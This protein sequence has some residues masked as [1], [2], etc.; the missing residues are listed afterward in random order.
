MTPALLLRAGWRQWRQQP[1]QPVLAIAGIALGVAVVLAVAIATDSARLSLHEALERLGGRATHTITAG[2]AGVAQDVYRRLRVDAGL[3]E[4]APVVEGWLQPVATP[5]RW[6]R[7]LGFDPFAE[8]GFGRLPGVDA[9]VDTGALLTRPR[10]ILLPAGLAAQLGLRAGDTVEVRIGEHAT[11]LDVAGT[12]AADGGSGDWVIADIATAQVLLGL[13]DRITRID[14]RLDAAAATALAA[15][16]PPGVTLEAAGARARTG[17]RLTA[18]FELNLTAMSLLALLVGTFLIYETM[19]FSVLRR[20]ALFGSLR[21]LGVTRRE[22]LAQVLLEAAALGVLGTA[23][24]LLLGSVLGARL[25]PLVGRTVNDLYYPLVDTRLHLPPGVFAGCAALGL[26]ATVLAALAPAWEAA[27]SAPGRASNRAQYENRWRR[28]SRQLLLGAAALGAAAV[29]VLA[30]SDGLPGGFGAL[31]LLVLAAT[32]AT[33]R[34]LLAFTAVLAPS[35]ERRTG[36]LARLAVRDL[37]RN[38]SRTAVAAA[39][40]AVAFGAALGVTLMV[41]SFRAGVTL[42]LEDL[43]RADVYAAPLAGT[44]GHG[45]VPLAPAVI[46]AWRTVPGVVAIATYRRFD[47]R[48]DEQPV[49]LIA[50]TLPPAARAGYRLSDGPP[51]RAWAA[52]DAGAVLVSEPLAYR[53]KLAPGA[54]LRLPTDAGTRDFTVAGVFHDYGSE[55]GRILLDH[56]Q[57]GHFWA[58]TRIGSVG[59]FVAAGADPTAVRARLETAAAPLQAVK[60]QG[61]R[62]ILALSLAVFERTFTITALLRALAVGVAFCGVLSSLLAL[63]LERARDFA[64]LRAL[65]LTPAELGRLVSLECGVLGL[66]SGLLALPLGLG[67]GVLLIEVINRR[68]F[69]W[70]MPWAFDPAALLQTVLLALVAALLAGVYPSWRLAHSRP[71]A[72]LR[73]E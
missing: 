49:Q 48:I 4:A 62:D 7:L 40:L 29:A 2:P 25:V 30:G 22:L 51:E 28:L 32:L 12:F 39:A 34:L 8:T 27:G 18:A 58:D 19:T 56:A 9:D 1:W 52:F 66:A 59:V 46:A 43:L 3:H 36:P 31:L 53:L 63:Q 68:A 45:F 72:A 41:D 71:A 67:I 69:G 35:A 60:T 47:T 65:G 14:L 38:L 57:L 61:N 50:A 24:G 54:T 6:L 44:D 55:H 70:T 42:W 20:R 64:V 15:R 16:L 73:E 10:A 26:G 17:E 5:G 37:R 33:P 23:V 21:A 11:T 13:G